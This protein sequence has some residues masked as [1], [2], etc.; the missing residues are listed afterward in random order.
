MTGERA[1]PPEAFPV[2]QLEFPA[3]QSQ[4]TV[5]K[6]LVFAL[7]PNS[8]WPRLS[9]RYPPQVQACTYKTLSTQQESVK[10]PS[11]R[12]ALKFCLSFKE[13]IPQALII[14]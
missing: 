3:P 13:C 5:L 11:A 10:S 8:T 2:P 1:C 14:P 9:I 7:V 12:Y 6:H 4:S